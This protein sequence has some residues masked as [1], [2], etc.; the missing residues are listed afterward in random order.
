[1]RLFLVRHAQAESRGRWHGPDE[2]RPLTKKGRR[3]ASGLAA[4]LEDRP[5]T[6]I[7]SSPAVRCIDTVT[8]LAER[9]GVKVEVTADLLEGADTE[10]VVEMCGRLASS[11]DDVVLC[12][13]GDVIPEVLRAL[14]GDGL[15]FEDDPRWAK[16][17]TWVLEGKKGR[18]VTARYV[19]PVEA[20]AV[21]PAG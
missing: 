7:L 17:S 4:L 14:A 12:T 10:A 19:A 8:P 11:N 13:H 3:Q 16:G 2:L 5:I 6:R 20:P 18:F 21:T 15:R 9:V 1:M